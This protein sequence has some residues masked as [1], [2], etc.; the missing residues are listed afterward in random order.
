MLTQYY[1]RLFPFK[2]F[3]RWMSYADGQLLSS[4]QHMH[5]D[6]LPKNEGS[7]YFGI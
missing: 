1:Q 5:F 2:K 4:W 3:V 7:S 6:N